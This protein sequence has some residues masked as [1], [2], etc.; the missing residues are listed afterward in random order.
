MLVGTLLTFQHSGVIVVPDLRQAW[1]PCDP[2]GGVF[3]SSCFS[4]VKDLKEF[5]TGVALY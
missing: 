4:Q 1:L 2:S 5:G 3:P